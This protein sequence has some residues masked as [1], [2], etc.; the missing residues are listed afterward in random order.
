IILSAI[1]YTALIILGIDENWYRFMQRGTFAYQ[2][3]CIPIKKHR[4]VSHTIEIKYHL[5]SDLLNNKFAENWINSQEQR[6]D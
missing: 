3:L 1:S 5:E 6:G 2:A 4:L